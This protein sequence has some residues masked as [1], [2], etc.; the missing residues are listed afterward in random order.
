MGLS[1]ASPRPGSDAVHLPLPR[2]H[3]VFARIPPLDSSSESWELPEPLCPFPAGCRQAW[4]RWALLTKRHKPAVSWL[5]LG[6]DGLGV[7]V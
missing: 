4:G 5:L 7:P 3:P 1:P 6:L 2:L